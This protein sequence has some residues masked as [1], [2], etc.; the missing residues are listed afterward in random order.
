M[1]AALA[2]VPRQH[3]HSWALGGASL[4]SALRRMSSSGA[5]LKSV[6]A[7]AIPDQ[8]VRVE[9]FFGAAATILPVCVRHNS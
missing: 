6:L 1:F 8:Q 4:G 9:G 7:A 2:A 5:E 3:A